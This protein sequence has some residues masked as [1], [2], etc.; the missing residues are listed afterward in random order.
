MNIDNLI[1]ELKESKAYCEQVNGLP[2]CKNCGLDFEP[3]I[4]ALEAY[5]KLCEGEDMRWDPKY[6]DNLAA[7]QLKDYEKYKVFHVQ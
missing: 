7:E 5:Q 6:V 3:I 4:Q 1:K 2:T